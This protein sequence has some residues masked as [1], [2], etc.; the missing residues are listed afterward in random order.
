MY[1]PEGLSR[2]AICQMEGHYFPRGHC[3][4]GEVNYSSLGYAGAL[5]RWP[6]EWGV[7]EEEAEKRFAL[8]AEKEYGDVP[9]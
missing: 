9:D 1:L 7:T 3:S 2:W 5:T 4:C 8:S 6:K